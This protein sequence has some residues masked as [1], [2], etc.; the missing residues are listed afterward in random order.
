MGYLD[1]FIKRSK[2]EMGIDAKKLKQREETIEKFDEVLSG[3][4]GEIEALESLGAEVEGTKRAFAELKKQRKELA[5]ALKEGNKKKA[6]EILTDLTVFDEA[7]HRKLNSFK[8]GAQ[9]AIEAKVSRE[10]AEELMNK[11]DG[12]SDKM[13]SQCKNSIEKLREEIS[14]VKEKGL[15]DELE[16]E[17]NSFDSKLEEIRTDVDNERV[18]IVKILEKVKKTSEEFQKW[19]E[20]NSEASERTDVLQGTIKGL[21]AKLEKKAFA[22]D[23]EGLREE[24]NEFRAEMKGRYREN[25]SKLRAELE[26]ARSEGDYIPQERD[27]LTDYDAKLKEIE[28]I[29]GEEKI[30]IRRFY[31]KL[32]QISK[33]TQLLFSE[34]QDSSVKLKKL[35]RMF[36]QLHG[37]F[38]EMQ[39]VEEELAKRI[40]KLSGTVPAGNYEEFDKKIDE[41]ASSVEKLKKQ[42]TAQEYEAV[43]KDIG[44]LKEQVEKLRRKED[45]LEQEQKLL[46]DMESKMEEM[47]SGKV[48]KKKEANE[49][50]QHPELELGELEEE[51]KEE[52]VAEIEKQLDKLR[53]YKKRLSKGSEPG[54]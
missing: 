41:L 45:K 42:K 2:D 10:E 21:S 44:E 40:K 8:K 32:E 33:E 28:A 20:K 46:I 11:L 38:R 1:K 47:L 52:P 5:N 13:L 25:V 3:I 49:V 12:L 6:N 29:I 16:E 15:T 54:K 39:V 36:K 51:E 31:E 22:E 17:L 23:V 30:D 35:H 26:G 18:D 37:E 9:R 53:E 50:E 7:V 19:A 24:F 48:P 4:E 14:R 43:K 27:F 34:S